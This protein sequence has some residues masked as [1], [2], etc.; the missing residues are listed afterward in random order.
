MRNSLR[1][2]I[3][4]TLALATGLFWASAGGSLGER[5]TPGGASE[6]VPETVAHESLESVGHETETLARV[7]TP[8]ASK[9]GGI[10]RAGDEPIGGEGA[11]VPRALRV[12]LSLPGGISSVNNGLVA[13][14]ELDSNGAPKD[15][16][17]RIVES[18]HRSGWFELALEPWC[19]GV[20][21][22]VV[23]RAMGFAP[24]MQ[25]VTLEPLGR[26][27][28]LLLT[29]EQG[30]KLRGQV[31]HR[32]KPVPNWTVHLDLRFGVP[33]VFHAGEEGFWFDGRFVEKHCTI[34]TDQ[35]GRF[36]VRGL[37]EDRYDLH[38]AYLEAG[39]PGYYAEAIQVGGR[40]VLIDLTRA[41][42][43]I[44]AMGS[45]GPLA[46][47]N[48]RLVH[49][50]EEITLETELNPVVV[51][52]PDNVAVALEA[53]HD[54]H[55]TTS[56]EIYT[57]V[58]GARSTVVI[59]MTYVERPSLRVHLPGSHA[60]GIGMVE[61][62]YLGEGDHARRGSLDLARAPNVDT[63]WVDVLPLDPGLYAFRIKS[64]RFFISEAVT[65]TISMDGVVDLFFS[66]HQGG[67]YELEWPSLPNAQAVQWTV[68]ASDGT[69]VST[70]TKQRGFEPGSSFW[71]TDRSEV[72]FGIG[73]PV[74]Q[75]DTNVLAPGTYRLNVES[76]QHERHVQ[77]FVIWANQTTTVAIQLVPSAERRDH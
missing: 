49:G 28:D 40:E 57:G 10:E 62:D 12:R 26:P 6:R 48:V 36:G 18:T 51:G 1:I 30:A 5:A 74:L 58:G 65:S 53:R 67:R 25:R 35:S 66:G 22:L 76:T 41:E 38:T 42:V 61:V 47:V 69:T 72:N 17:R 50:D 52:L 71:V 4:V 7:R 15:E 3:A 39:I 24:A 13:I 46:G 19:L 34:K 43:A 9:A 75:P 44:S 33:G 20:P 2:L 68:V 64:D 16:G 54:S 21:V 60:A 63:Y 59:P 73:R 37:V 14:I 70:G 27:D 55:S 32:G 56:A 77:E 31:I 45:N 23:G 8:V 11:R 29:L